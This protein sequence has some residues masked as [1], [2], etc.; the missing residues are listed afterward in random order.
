MLPEDTK[1]A[2]AVG[3]E[4]ADPQ[5]VQKVKELVLSL[6][7]T[8][9][10]LKI[11]PPEHASAI[12]FRQDFISKLKTFLDNYQRLE[13][14]ISEFGFYYQ[15]KLVY[16]DEISSKSLPFFFFKDGLRLLAF[17]QGMDDEEISDFLDIIRTESAKPTDE[18]DVVN[19]LWLKD[20]P[21]L[22][23]YAPE[24]FIESRILEERTESLSKRGLQVIPQELA[25]KVVD[26]KV[27][28]QQLFSGRL[29]LR[30]EEKQAIN[31]FVDEEVPELPENWQQNFA[32]EAEGAESGTGTGQ[33]D[34]PANLA[35]KLPV[36]L[37]LTEEELSQ[38]NRLL[39]RNRKLSP[40]EEFINLMLEIMALEDNEKQFETNLN[41]LEDFYLENIKNGHFNI[42]I[43]LNRKIK[44]LRTLLASSPDDRPS[45]LDAFLART[46]DLKILDEIR[47]LVDNKV[48]LNYE[49]LY[50]YLVQF[51]EAAVPFL[52]EMYEKVENQAFRNLVRGFFQE[53]MATDPG[54]VASQL[55][56]QK[57][58]LTSA[59]I[60]LM[61]KQ[62]AKKI[63]PYF[64]SFLAMSSRE[65]KLKAVEAL[66]SFNDELANKILMAFM[67]DKD[68][69]VRLKATTNLKFLGDTSRLGQLM[70]EVFTPKFRAR[71]FEEKKA[72]FEFLGRTKSEEAFKFLKK[73]FLKK[74]WRRSTTELK[75]CAV[76]GLEKMGSKEAIDLLRRGEHF[77]NR[78]VREASA[79]A[80]VRL[81]LKNS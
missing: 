72:L 28:R 2:K 73:I 6:A 31:A 46:A 47:K 10:A 43:I 61:E 23:Y 45:Q 42:P 75:I 59:L 41:I 35:V 39:E 9:S 56:E 19:A 76:A 33:V 8:I 34:Q 68:Q 51:E 29:E 7:N 63:I 40:E 53:K 30:P 22:Q 18:S 37:Q 77:F 50:E 3:E 1:P 25:G 11:F 71:S 57:P 32:F 55:D 12:H 5:A 4:K 24:E 20:F 66:A 44:E 78:Q 81:A 67:N 48:Q 64:T 38:L 13:L 17:Y 54:L 58:Q 15:D 69:E 16:Q 80:L 49:A 21:N 79:E 70:A 74:S 14:S 52:A 36:S 26:I 65:L 60:D 62:P 27:D